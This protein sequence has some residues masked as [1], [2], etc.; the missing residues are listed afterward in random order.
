MFDKQ[1]IE[2]IV[3]SDPLSLLTI[4][5]EKVLDYINNL[6]PYSTAFEI[7][8]MY[9][10][11]Y[12]VEDFKRI[13]D[14][15][16]VQNDSCEQRYRIPNGLKGIM[17]V[18]NISTQLKKNSSLNLMSGI[19]YHVDCTDCWP[20]IYNLIDES[21][22]IK[23]WI[24]KEL[25][26]WLEKDDVAS[27]R[28]YGSWFRPNDL[29][30]IEFRLGEMTFEYPRILRRIIHVNQIVR[31][32]KDELNVK[33]P[34]FEPIN[35]KAQLHYQSTLIREDKERMRLEAR[36]I[37]LQAEEKAFDKPKEV[38]PLDAIKDQVRKRTH[39]L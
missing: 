7:E 25:D 21:E 24:L 36:L 28:N 15:M 20:K 38:D 3:S 27:N 6:I 16:S 22:E 2:G 26:K 33:D 37:N 34:T 4:R 31:K 32:Y 10:T 12:D 30:T 13:P 19:H 17:C 29:H 35:V 5:D 39:K 8:C 14:I 23:D 11:K 18:Y 9:G 1:M